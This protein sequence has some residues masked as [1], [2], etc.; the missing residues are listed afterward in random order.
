MTQLGQHHAASIRGVQATLAAHAE[1]TAALATTT[2]SLREALASPKARGQWGERMAEDVLRLAGFVEHVNYEKQ[3]A[4]TGRSGPARLHLPAAEGARPVHGREVSAGG[5]PAVPRRR[6]RCRALGP[7]R[8]LLRDVRLRVR[9][10]AARGSTPQQGTRPS[11]DYVL[12]FLPNETL[13]AFIHENDPGLV[14]DT[15][16]QKV[17]LC[18][19]LTL[20]AMLGIIRQAFDN[21][22]VEQTSE[23]I[24]AVLGAFEQQWQKFAGALDA[25]GRRIDSAQKAYDDLAGT[26]KRALERPLARLASLRTDRGIAAD[27]RYLPDADVVSFDSAR[28]ELGGVTGGRHTLPA[29][30]AA[31]RPIGGAPFYGVDMALL[32]YLR[33]E[34]VEDYADGLFSRRDALRRSCCSACRCRRPTALL[35][36]CGGDNGGTSATTSAATTS[37]GSPGT[38]A[39]ASGGRHHG[40]GEPAGDDDRRADHRCRPHH[41]RHRDAGPADRGDQLHRPRRHVAGLV[42]RRAGPHGRR[43]HHP[44]EP[45]PHA[46][47][48]D[49]A[50]P[51]RGQRLRRDVPRPAVRAREAP[52]P[53]PTRPRPP[54]LLGAATEESLVEDM[55][56][57]LTEL[58]QRVPGAKL[59]IVGFCFGGGQVWSLLA[60]GEPRLA[61]AVPFYGPGP[62][63]AD[64]SGSNAAVLGVYAEQDARVNATKDAMDAALTAAGLTHDLRGLPGRRPRLLQRHRSPATTPSK[65]PWPTYSPWTGSAGT[66]PD[67][68]RG[69]MAPMSQPSLDLEFDDGADPTFTVRELADAVNQVLR[70]GFR[71][72][73]WVHGEI[74]GI[75]Q[76]GGHVY[77]TLTDHTDEGGPASRWRCSPTPSTGCAPCWPATGS[78]WPTASPCASTPPPTCTPRRAGSRSSW[79]ASTCGS[80]SAS[81]PPT[82]TPCWPG[83]PRPASSVATP[84][85]P[86]PWCR[87]G[88]GWSP[89]GAAPAWHDV[90]HELEGSGIG[91]RLAHVDVRVQ[92]QEAAAAVAG[93]VRTLARRPVDVIVVVRGG[94]SRTD[95]AAFDDERIALAIARS[96]VPVLTGLGHEVDRS[97]ADHV[98]RTAYKTPTACA[99]ALVDRVRQYTVAVAAAGRGIGRTTMAVRL[100][101]QRIGHAS[102]RLQRQVRRCPGHGRDPPGRRRRPAGPPPTRRPP[103]VRDRPRR[104]GG[105]GAG[106][107]SGVGAGPRSDITRRP[108]GSLVRAASGLAP[109]DELVTTLVDGT[110]VSTVGGQQAEGAGR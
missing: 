100:A 9:E 86:F 23:E 35:A 82:A 80:R 101:D 78:G 47:L 92:G 104:G 20:F 43:P 64:F 107:R 28:G 38:S 25:V 32:D 103:P 16:G 31:R 36:A 96:P 30:V 77:F 109:G 48:P 18:S 87:C 68:R 39:P 66:S 14:D 90:L 45:G 33:G 106:P 79:T 8:H 54:A 53:S 110:V 94:G 19:P 11:V 50:R 56:A 15:L 70:R 27:E 10:L 26:R 44:R 5:L 93:A 88:S 57:G 102:G 71:E 37:A 84:A 51:V 59:A 34:I 105:P 95:L 4:V 97:V 49:P 58:Q 63:D 6:Y 3:T 75:Q 41:R 52:P 60:A 61:A 98:A 29:P 74:E 12:L 73:V 22:M 42:R 13:S 72:G 65:P 46:P 21:F 99:A 108:D 85:W 55:R 2:Q 17:V 83:S 24:L 67:V 1:T 7:P 40:G 62:A 81:W 76:R 69:I 91:F 89:A